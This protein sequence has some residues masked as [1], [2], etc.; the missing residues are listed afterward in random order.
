MITSKDISVVV[1]VHIWNADVAEMLMGALNSIPNNID[2]NV[3]ISTVEGCT[4]ELG[5]ELK[6]KFNDL[7]IVQDSKDSCFQAL[8]NQG[9]ENV[10]TEW[11]SI[12]EYDDEYAPKWF[13]NFIKY[14]EYNQKYNFFLPLNDLYNVEGGQDT[15]VGNGNEAVWASSF[16]SEIGVIDEKSLDDYFDFYLD[17]AIIK[18]ETWKELGGLKASIKLTF[19]YEFMLRAGHKGEKFY[20][21]PKVGY[22]HVLGREGSLMM[23][24]RSEIDEKE[25]DFWFRTAKKEAHFKEDRPQTYVP[26][27]ETKEIAEA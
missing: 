5:E 3:I 11:F 4:V 7:K 2:I 15:F 17:G 24:Y 9:V 21:V 22:A 1:P 8:V 10:T 6:S 14:Q 18:T 25:S 19:W 26:K 12:L 16:S 27:E 20:V 13:D 23:K